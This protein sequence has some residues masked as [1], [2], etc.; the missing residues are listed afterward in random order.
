MYFASQQYISWR[1]LYIYKY[2]MPCFQM[3]NKQGRV[4]IKQLYNIIDHSLVTISLISFTFF[5]PSLF[6]KSE[7]LISI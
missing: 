3:L 6:E 4:Y 1:L 2:P 7:I 5:T